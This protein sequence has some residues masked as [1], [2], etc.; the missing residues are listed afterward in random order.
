VRP[1]DLLNRKQIQLDLAKIAVA[2]KGKTVLV[3]GAGGT[4]GGE[5]CRQVLRFEPGRLVL[6]ENHAT[7]LFYI[8][9]ELR[10]RNGSDPVFPVLGDIRD[11]ALVERV[12]SEHKPQVVLH[13]AAHKHVGQ[14]EANVAEGI[15]NNVVG[16]HNVARAADKHGAEVFL[17]VSTDKAVRPSSVM[18]ATKRVA[19]YI[20]RDL[21]E[22]SRTRYTAVRFGNV[23]GSSGS[24]LEIFQK[25][26]AAGG[27][28][29]VTDAEA[30]R[31]FMTVEEAVQLI[32]QALSMTHG[33][34]IFVLKMGTPVRILEMAQNLVILSG[35]EPGKD[36]EIRVTGLKPGEK[37]N[38]ELM[39]K[40]EAFDE[41][42]HPDIYIRK[43]AP[44][45]PDNF[46]EKL[47]DLE[48]SHHKASAD[49]LVRKLKALVPT[50][51]PDPVH[52]R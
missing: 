29:T 18:G 48:K 13:A 2:L 24:V 49:E 16:T 20:A 15:G 28:L 50:F 47:R 46:P 25:Q 23:L 40:A 31:F 42:A 36:V 51:K 8:E 35:L 43:K 26:L 30:T 1:V 9:H 17:L 33:G 4:I 22:R 12:F 14:L 7:S 34:E 27:P 6:L 37:L 5:L 52:Q 11:E 32:L 38:E 10:S 19:E 45:P 41:S 3:T 44:I 21:G 39:E